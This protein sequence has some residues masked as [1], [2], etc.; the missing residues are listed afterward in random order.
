M[1]CKLVLNKLILQVGDLKTVTALFNDLSGL[2]FAK[3]RQANWLNK[4]SATESYSTYLQIKANEFGLDE[5]KGTLLLLSN[6]GETLRAHLFATHASIINNKTTRI[7]PD[8][9]ASSA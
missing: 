6:E 7:S 5:W 1:H 2:N 3:N 4:M 8:Q 9:S